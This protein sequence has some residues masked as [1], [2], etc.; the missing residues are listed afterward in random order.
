[1]DAGDGNV[2]SESKWGEAA[3]PLAVEDLLVRGS[4][5]VIVIHN[6]DRIN[7]LVILY[8]LSMNQ[9]L[10]CIELIAKLLDYQKMI[11]C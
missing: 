5:I 8:K 11:S 2:L 7:V 9:C 4:K 3:V 10:L 6:C 1:V